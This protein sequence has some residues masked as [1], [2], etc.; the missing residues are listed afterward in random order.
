MKDSVYEKE[1]YLGEAVSDPEF[2]RYEL[3]GK[4]DVS[5]GKLDVY[6]DPVEVY[7]QEKKQFVVR[8]KVTY[9]R[10]GP[11][12][13]SPARCVFGTLTVFPVLFATF[14]D[15]YA[16]SLQK[17]CYK[18]YEWKRDDKDL[19]A[20]LAGTKT[21]ELVKRNYTDSQGSLYFYLYADGKQVDRRRLSGFKGEDRNGA[22]IWSVNNWFDFSQLDDDATLKVAVKNTRKSKVLMNTMGLS[23]EEAEALVFKGKYDGV[24]QYYYV[25]TKC[26]ADLKTNYYSDAQ[27]IV[28]FSGR[29]KYRADASWA[30]D[31]VA[32]CL[33][34]RFDTTGKNGYVRV[35]NSPT[36]AGAQNW[37][38]LYQAYGSVRTGRKIR[39]PNLSDLQA[40]ARSERVDITF[41]P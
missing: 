37:H 35:S 9:K 24:V 11:Y 33:G 39:D 41:E 26:N 38:L 29:Y 32:S 8:K 3:R 15:D 7:S 25:C 12:R 16:E 18:V 4:Y 14:D 34:E 19:P 2:L 6:V 20:E 40:C 22:Y 36:P 5:K 10:Y 27:R 21:V 1:R 23:S 13:Y 30:V 17:T 28:W 31:K